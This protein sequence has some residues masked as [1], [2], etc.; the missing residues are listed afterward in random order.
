MSLAPSRTGVVHSIK[1]AIRLF[2]IA[3]AGTIVF[4]MISYSKLDLRKAV[5]WIGLIGGT[6]VLF[7]RY[8]SYS[9]AERKLKT[10]WAASGIAL[11]IH[12]A[13]WVPIALSV[14]HFKPIWIIGMLAEYPALTYIREFFAVQLEEGRAPRL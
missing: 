14:R 11:L 12:C 5:P 1:H 8:L 7:G 13:I 2:G 4:I 6:A 10:F 3:V 9:A